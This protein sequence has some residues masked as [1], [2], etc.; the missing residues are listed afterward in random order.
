MICNRFNRVLV[1]ALF[2]TMTIFSG[3]QS[4][5]PFGFGRIKTGLTTQ[6]QVTRAT[7]V[8]MLKY[9]DRE[10]LAAHTPEFFEKL[11]H[12]PDFPNVSDYFAENSGSKFKLSNAGVYGPFSYP[13]DPA[14]PDDESLSRCDA[15]TKI[16]DE[17]LLCPRSSRTETREREMAVKLAAENGVDFSRFDL[18]GDGRVTTDELLVIVVNA[19]AP[20]FARGGA[21]RKLGGG[22][23]SVTGSHAVQ[24]CG[25]A[26]EFGE[27]ASFA[28]M[29]HE[30]SHL[31]GTSDIYGPWLNPYF[32]NNFAASLMGST[33][34]GRDDDRWTTHLDPW[35]KI[36]LGWANPRV[37]EINGTTG[38][39]Y[40]DPAHLGGTIPSQDRAPVI[41]YDPNRGPDEYF[42]LE[43]RQRTRSFIG[44]ETSD[45]LTG[46]TKKFYSYDA[47]TADSGIAV[48]HIQETANGDLAEFNAFVRRPNDQTLQTVLASDS[49]DFFVDRD[50]D[51][52]PDAILPGLDNILQSATPAGHDV[53]EKGKANR[54]YPPTQFINPPQRVGRLG[55]SYYWR[56]EHG[57]FQLA[58]LRESEGARVRLG[59]S[60]DPHAPIAVAYASPGVDFPDWQSISDAK[61]RLCYRETSLTPP[62]LGVVSLTLERNCYSSRRRTSPYEFISAVSASLTLDLGGPQERPINVKIETPM[63]FSVIQPDGPF[64]TIP[65]GQRTYTF[66][67]DLL[68]DFTFGQVPVRVTLDRG[69]GTEIKTATFQVLVANLPPGSGAPVTCDNVGQWQARTN[70][71]GFVHELFNTQLGHL[72]GFPIKSGPAPDLEQI[73]T[74]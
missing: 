27:Y 43:N 38:C 61:S 12:G 14:T 56:R 28:T 49:D 10:F 19:G 2:A 39:F 47:D 55:D 15:Y 50:H 64:V 54:V 26:G 4:K 35:H 71:L 70:A 32:T 25:R 67:V 30:T 20:G 7:I 51:G 31:F 68:A 42:I 46:A 60:L 11:F 5:I 21:V 58:F 62:P 34:T 52:A 73:L 33:V 13:D 40:L 1:I 57:E 72:F 69:D 74:P 44:S 3:C 59:R 48:W 63:V 23:V 9:R 29:A 17:T 36:Q 41:L 37:F 24:V 45:P 53:I 22:C 18:N 8:I 16:A 66:N 6:S 65:A